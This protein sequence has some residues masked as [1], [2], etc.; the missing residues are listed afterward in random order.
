VL[1]FRV[2]S[3]AG[4]STVAN[5][6]ARIRSWWVMCV[7]FGLAMVSGPRLSLGLFALTSFFAL[8]EFLTLTPTRRSDHLALF[9][10]FFLLLPLQYYF[11][12]IK[13]Y[14][15]TRLTASSSRAQ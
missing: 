14:V 12:A 6:N 1:S 8:R 9:G 10:A 11:V 15:P 2:K 7:I 5:L 4:R 3:D 13:W